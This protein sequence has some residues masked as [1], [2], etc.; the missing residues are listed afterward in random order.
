MSKKPASNHYKLFESRVMNAPSLSVSRRGEKNRGRRNETE[1]SDP[2]R[3]DPC[4]DWQAERS[5]I[6]RGFFKRS[7][8]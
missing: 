2:Q 6:E 3:R 7:R 8:N 4:L 5:K 1:I